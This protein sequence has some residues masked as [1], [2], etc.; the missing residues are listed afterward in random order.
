MLDRKEMSEMISAKLRSVRMMRRAL[1][2]SLDLLKHL[3]VG[4][5]IMC[6]GGIGPIGRVRV[7]VENIDNHNITI[8]PIMKMKPAAHVS[9]PTG[10]FF[11]NKWRYYGF[12]NTNP[13]FWDCGCEKNYIHEKRGLKKCEVCGAKQGDRPDSRVSEVYKYCSGGN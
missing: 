13:L 10:M 7:I 11:E 5:I 9:V 12:T 6:E 8:T 4:S 1:E 3:D 2:N